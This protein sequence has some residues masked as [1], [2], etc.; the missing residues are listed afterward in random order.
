MD[1]GKEES[2]TVGGRD[3]NRVGTIPGVARGWVVLGRC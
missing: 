2:V 1:A 3:H